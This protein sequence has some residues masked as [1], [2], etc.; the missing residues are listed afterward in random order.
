MTLNYLHMK[1]D[2]ELMSSSE[3]STR[4]QAL[5]IHLCSAIFAVPAFLKLITF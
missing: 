3:M 4:T 5:L 2:L 1:F